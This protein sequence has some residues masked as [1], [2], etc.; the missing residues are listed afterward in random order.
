M[1]PFAFHSRL[2]R[3]FMSIS[4][5]EFAYVRKLVADHAAI[6][7]EFGQEYLVESRLAAVAGKYGVGSASE[8]I[9]RAVTKPSEE[10][11]QKIIEAITTN[12]TLFFRDAHPFEALRKDLLPEFLQKNIRE[13]SLAIWCA[14]CSTGQE[15]YSIALLLREH[16]PQVLG[17]DLEILATDLSEEAL[18]RAR[19][20]RYSQFE[21]NRGL[22]EALL[23]KYFL[24]Q[25]TDWVLHDEVRPMV[26]FRHLNLAR[27]WPA[28]PQ[29]DLILL[30]NVLIYFSVPMKQK[31]LAIVR[32]CLKPN[33]Y[34]FLGTA[35]T[36][37]NLDAAFEQ[38]QFG[39]ASCYRLRQTA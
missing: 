30:R 15:P 31:I 22:P 11:K 6:N 36:A 23:L 25:G 18:A 27:N 35:E 28:L 1:L 17:W 20:A 19:E 24:H 12:E 32:R 16:F 37:M 38:V 8:F 33:G 2:I 34:L 7:L 4:A 26:N 14:A 29:F 10:L 5:S 13:R 39:R 9:S 3:R 21:V